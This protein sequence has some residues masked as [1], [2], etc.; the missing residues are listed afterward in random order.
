VGGIMILHERWR[1][2]YVVENIALLM[3]RS[4]VYPMQ[5]RSD[6]QPITEHGMTCRPTPMVIEVSSQDDVAAV[7]GAQA[8]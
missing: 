4:R 7:M 3:G 2:E 8:M 6:P 1:D 5:N